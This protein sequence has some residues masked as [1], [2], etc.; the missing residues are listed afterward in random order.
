MQY[1]AV[2]CIAAQCNVMQFSAVQYSA[3]QCIAAQCNVL[4]FSAVQLN[5][6]QCSAIQCTALQG[7]IFHEISEL[8]LLIYQKTEYSLIPTYF[9]LP[10]PNI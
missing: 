4:Q 9:I 1:S 2:Q 10:M 5:A 6:V 7:F 8:I 3:V